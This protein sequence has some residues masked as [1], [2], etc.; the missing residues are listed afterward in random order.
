MPVHSQLYA[1]IP[2][3]YTHASQLYAYTCL[4]SC[5]STHLH[6]IHMPSQ[7][8]AYTS[9]QY[10]YAQLVVCI[11]TCTVYI[12]LV[13]CMHTHLHSIHMPSQL[14]VYTPAQYTYASQLYV[15]TPAQYTYADA[16]LV[17]CRLY[18]YLQIGWYIPTR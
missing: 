18:G 2:A 3:Q 10:T 14:Y 17:V 13:S 4:V 11:H 9:A 5:M 15:Y 1:Y 16:Q 8:Y 7:L 12:C 6:S